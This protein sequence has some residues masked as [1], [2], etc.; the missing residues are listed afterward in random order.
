MYLSSNKS[1]C[2]NSC[3][4]D[5]IL[6]SN[7]CEKCYNFMPDCEIC[8]SEINCSKCLLSIYLY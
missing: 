1:K 3:E 8:S 5:D 6:I 2:V 4:N 7:K